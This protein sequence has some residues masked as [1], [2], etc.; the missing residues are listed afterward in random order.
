MRTIPHYL[1]PMIY[2]FLRLPSGRAFWRRSYHSLRTLVLEDVLGDPRLLDLFA[3]GAELPWGYGIGLDERCI[4]Y[5][6]F[7]AKTSSLSREVLD[8]GST[9]NNRLLLRHHRMKGKR[10]SII[11]LYPESACFWHLGVSYHFSDLRAMPFRSHWF[12]EIACL[13]T[14]EHVG[15]DNRLYS[16]ALTRCQSKTDD[17]EKALLEIRRVL[18]PGGRLLLTLPFGKYQNW[19]IFQQF[20]AALLERAAE[21]F[22]PSQRL[23]T[24]YLYRRNGWQIAQIQDCENCSYSDFIIRLWS[25]NTKDLKHDPDYAVGARAVVCSV[26]HRD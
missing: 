11:T 14:L 26:W 4:E 1:F 3:S 7:L 5:P 19:G 20:D 9:L 22:R 18:K 12:D 21:V 13:S 8:A 2:L 15:M 24:F 10:L 17:F 23:D 25:P 6:W 16:K